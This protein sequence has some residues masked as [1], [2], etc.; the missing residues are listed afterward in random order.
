MKE[1]WNWRDYYHSVAVFL[2][3]SNIDSNQEKLD[4]QIKIIV[5]RTSFKY[6]RYLPNCFKFPNS[7]GI[8]PVK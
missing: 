1:E 3:Y 8:D 5:K 6:L 4:T 7:S 2:N